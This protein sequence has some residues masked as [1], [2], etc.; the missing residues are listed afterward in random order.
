MS[1][2]LNTIA[3]DPNRWTPTKQ[4]Y[5]QLIDLLPAFQEHRFHQ[6]EVWQYHLT[7]LPEDDVDRLVERAQTLGIA[8]PIVGLYPALHN[9]G[10]AAVQEQQAMQAAVVRAAR[11]GARTIKIF[12]G[13]LG[14]AAVDASAYT[15]SIAFAQ[16]LAGWAADFGMTVTAE[17]HPDTLCDTVEATLHFLEDVAA[18][19]VKLCFQ[20]YDFTDTERT[21]HDY[22]SLHAHV[23][24]V[25]LQG[26]CNDQMCLLERADI[27]YRRLFQALSETNFQGDVCI[28]FVEDCVVADPRDFDQEKVL[29]NVGLDRQFVQDV[30]AQVGLDIG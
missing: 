1:L 2:L 10:V 11:L 9:E 30:A 12:A 24:H 27:N 22:G 23:T 3:L 7:T 19:N 16:R 28:E 15:R 18:P 5:F 4:P 8:F 20:P 14:S 29:T 21:L 25:H 26:R 13:Q 17:T 6:L